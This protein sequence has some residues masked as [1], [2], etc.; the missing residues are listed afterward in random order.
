MQTSKNSTAETIKEIL[1]NFLEFNKEDKEE[2]DKIIKTLQEKVP[3][4]KNILPKEFLEKTINHLTELEIPLRIKMKVYGIIFNALEVS[5]NNMAISSMNNTLSELVKNQ[6]L[7]DLEEPK[8]S[9]SHPFFKGT[10]G[11]A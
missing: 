3:L 9:S 5:I 2:T 6:N 4:N 8:E 7:D 1:Q 10:V 11:E